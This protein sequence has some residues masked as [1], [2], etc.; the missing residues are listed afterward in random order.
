MKTVPNY[1]NTNSLTMSKYNNNNTHSD[2]IEYAK[3]SFQ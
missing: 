1:L 2:L 3:K